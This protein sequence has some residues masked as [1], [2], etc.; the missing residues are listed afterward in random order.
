MQRRSPEERA[1][2][3]TRWM[4]KNLN[5]TNEQRTKV[6]DIIL[7]YAREADKTN[8]DV[9]AGN[10]K[11]VDKQ[12]IRKGREQE[13]K[14]VLTPAQYEKLQAHMQEMKDRVRERRE[15]MQGQY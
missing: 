9:P 4:E 7:Y 3:Q 12:R 14:D 11:K 6:Y 15:G 10:E 1:D 5:I 8:A 13:L 2:N